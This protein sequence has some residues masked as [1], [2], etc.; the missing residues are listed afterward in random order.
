MN[1]RVGQK[2]VCVDDEPC[3]LEACKENGIARGKVYTIRNID[4]CPYAKRSGIR[5]EEVRLTIH[6]EIGRERLFRASRFHPVVETK[7]DISIFHQ[8]L[9]DVEAGKQLEIV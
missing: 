8:I 9:R 2:V 3:G 6:E 4:T 7:T 1:F 5:L